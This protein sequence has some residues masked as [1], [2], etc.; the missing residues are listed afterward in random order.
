MLSLP[1]IKSLVRTLSLKL[2]VKPAHC[3][4]FVELRKQRIGSPL[5]EIESA[6]LGVAISHERAAQVPA[7]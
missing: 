6:F 4:F 5:Q 2:C 1:S 7:L 3:Q